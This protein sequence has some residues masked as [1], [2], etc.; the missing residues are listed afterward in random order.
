[1]GWFKFYKAVNNAGCTGFKFGVDVY[2][3]FYKT[4]RKGMY[5]RIKD[6]QLWLGLTGAKFEKQGT[7]VVFNGKKLYIRRGRN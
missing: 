5:L 4:P 3:D 7:R 1:M 2:F 6:A